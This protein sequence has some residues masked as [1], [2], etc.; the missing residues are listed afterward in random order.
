[1]ILT[2]YLDRTAM[3]FWRVFLFASVFAMSF[4]CLVP[5]RAQTPPHNVILFIPDGLRADIVSSET[6]PTFAWVRDRG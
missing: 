5:A 6:A 2:K 1:M 4:S 3:R